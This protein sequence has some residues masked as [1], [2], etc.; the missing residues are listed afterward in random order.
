M[1]T[2]VTSEEFR[3]WELEFKKRVCK[4]CKS[5]LLLPH[6]SISGITRCL[7]CNAI[8]RA[9]DFPRATVFDQITTSP[10]VLAEDLIYDVGKVWASTLIVDTSFDSYEEAIAATV[11]K[12][13]EAA[14]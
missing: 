9:E 3:V 5:A 4:R 14:K 11:A 2:K 13:K 12:L 1:K 7:R 8:G 10:E 6:E